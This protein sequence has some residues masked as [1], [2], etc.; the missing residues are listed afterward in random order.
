MPWIDRITRPEPRECR[1]FGI[2]VGAVLVAAGLFF[3]RSVGPAW[4]ALAAP[5]ALLLVL[6]VFL[7]RALAVP[8]ALWISFGTI[9]QGIVVAVVFAAAYFTVFTG[10]GLLLRLTRRDPLRVRRDPGRSLWIDRRERPFTTEDMERP[11]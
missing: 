1:L 4:P 7:P 2:A 9:L 11:F 6:G 8:A 10:I 3:R 5:G